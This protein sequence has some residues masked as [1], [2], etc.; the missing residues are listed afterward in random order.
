MSGHIHNFTDKIQARH[1][2]A[3][4][5]LGRKLIRIHTAHSHFGFFKALSTSRDNDPF[6]YLSLK[7]SERG[8]RQGRNGT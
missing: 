5:S 1:M 4:H 3:F 7:I 2:A 8:I 6:M